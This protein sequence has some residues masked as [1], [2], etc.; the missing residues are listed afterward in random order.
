MTAIAFCEPDYVYS[1]YIAEFWNTISSF[2]YCVAGILYL[3]EL[4]R[5]QKESP[6]AF[7][8]RAGHRYVI[9]GWSIILIGIGSALLHATQTWWGELADEFAMLVG[10]LT[11]LF[12]MKDLHPL[13]SGSRRYWFYGLAVAASALVTAVYLMI[14]VHGLFATLFAAIVGVCISIFATSPLHNALAAAK[15]RVRSGKRRTESAHGPSFVIGTICSAIGFAAW[16]VDQSCVRLSWRG[17]ELGWVYLLHSVWHVMT[18]IAAWVYCL[19]ILRV[20]LEV[21][22]TDTFARTKSGSFVPSKDD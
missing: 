6:G 5:L 7:A 8:G 3:R 17:T 12:C 14:F 9:L 16:M 1:P 15:C 18:A 22:H 21:I 11:F 4:G 20:R 19:L 13:T 2:A 10:A